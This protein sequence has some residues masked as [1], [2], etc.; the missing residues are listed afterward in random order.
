MA[1]G[2]IQS[3]RRIKIDTASG[4]VTSGTIVSQEGFV[5]VVLTSASTGAPF[6]IGV[7]GVWK[8]AVPAN[9]VKGDYLGA[10]GANG[11]PTESTTPTLTRTPG[12][13]D[14]IFGRALTDRDSAGYSYVLLAA[15][16]AARASTQV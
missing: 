12:N 9:T 4:T 14:T 7:E 15:Q 11:A 5:G 10:A 6:W 8:V 13:S 3:G 16:S 1:T 2:F